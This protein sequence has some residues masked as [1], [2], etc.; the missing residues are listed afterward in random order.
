M[1]LH[2]NAPA[3]TTIRVSQFLAQKM[4]A[5]LDHPPYAPDL[6]PADFFLF[7]HLKA[8]IKGAG[9]ADVNAI[10]DHLTTVLRSIPQ[11]TLADSFQK[12]YQRCKTCVVA[13][14]DYF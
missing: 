9:F 3:H 1:L 10:K 6:A 2:D 12:L 14:S 7:P 4:V 5:V 8:T 11:E 13:D